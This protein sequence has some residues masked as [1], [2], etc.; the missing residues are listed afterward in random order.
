[1]TKQENT[2]NLFIT[3]EADKYWE[4]LHS[5]NDYDQAWDKFM[6]YLKEEVSREVMANATSYKNPKEMSVAISAI[7][8]QRRSD[9][10]KL[11]HKIGSDL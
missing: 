4:I 2:N 5:T 9:C 3:S 6:D 7:I 10:K 11:F 8:K 1:M